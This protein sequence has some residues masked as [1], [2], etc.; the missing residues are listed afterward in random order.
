MAKWRFFPPDWEP[1]EKILKWAHDLGLS[2]AQI[3]DQLERIKDHEFNPMRSCPTRTFRRW[4][5]NSIEWGRV[6]PTVQRDYK[7]FDDTPPTPEEKAEE[8]RKW[9]EQMERFEK[10]RAK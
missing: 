9:R 8:Q 4:I 3:T 10:M 1:D 5:R 2:D 7:L 6:V